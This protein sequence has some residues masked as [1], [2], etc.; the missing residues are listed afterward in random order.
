MVGNPETAPQLVKYRHSS[1]VMQD[2][3]PLA[4]LCNGLFCAPG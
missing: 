2:S 4:H 1:T 3:F